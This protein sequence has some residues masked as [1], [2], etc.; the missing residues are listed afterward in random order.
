MIKRHL[1]LWMTAATMGVGQAWAQEPP[2]PPAQPLSAAPAPPR[3]AE[4]PKPERPG[5]RRPGRHEETATFLG[6]AVDPVPDWLSEQLNLPDGFGLLVSYVTPGSPAEAAG[7]K[8]HDILKQINDQKLANP[9]QLSALVQSFPEGTDVSLDILRKGQDTRLTAKLVKRKE[10]AREERAG[11]RAERDRE[12]RMDASDEQEDED[13]DE[14][15]KGVRQS[16]MRPEIREMQREAIREAAERGREAAEQGREMAQQARDQARQARDQAR[17]AQ[18][19]IMILR[20]KDGVSSTTK[21]D[22][23]QGRIVIRDDKGETKVE[24]EGD[25]RTVIVTDPHGKETYHGSVK[26]APPGVLD[27]LVKF[28]EALKLAAP[29]DD[30]G[31]APNVGKSNGESTPSPSAPPVAPPGN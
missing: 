3:P 14:V 1:T 23:S 31:S 17:Q 13:L 9:E 28:G 12:D 4:P 22:L 15:K 10:R 21:I 7:V 30:K 19:E 29:S 6:V 2:P 27:R 8:P 5:D 25:H 11:R 20:D 24:G 18:R 16:M 26:E